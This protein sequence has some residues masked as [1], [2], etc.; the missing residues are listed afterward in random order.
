MPLELD[1][2]AGACGP[3]GSAQQGGG[4]WTWDQLLLSLAQGSYWSPGTKQAA[5]GGELAT[6]AYYSGF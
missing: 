4:Y 1:K 2:P 3:G 6:K 5:T